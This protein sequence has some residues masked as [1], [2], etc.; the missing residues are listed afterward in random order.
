MVST[1]IVLEVGCKY[2][3]CH[4]FMLEESVVLQEK[5]CIH[6]SRCG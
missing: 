4:Y 5:I 1:T 2:E 3:P 6:D